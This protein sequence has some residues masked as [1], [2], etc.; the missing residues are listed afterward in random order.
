MKSEDTLY[1]YACVHMLKYVWALIHNR[2]W[3]FYGPVLHWGKERAVT[4]RMKCCGL[5]SSDLWTGREWLL[6]ARRRG[7]GSCRHSTSLWARKAGEMRVVCHPAVN[8]RKVTSSACHM[9]GNALR[10]KT[11]MQ[12]FEL[13]VTCRK[14][15]TAQAYSLQF[16]ASRSTS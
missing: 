8:V 1:V 7:P 9:G 12:P 6:P 13:R 5:P 2:S 4:W 3:H 10:E 11:L 15:E 14:T 16:S